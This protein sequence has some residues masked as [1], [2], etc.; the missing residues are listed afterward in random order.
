MKNTTDL[1]RYGENA[2]AQFLKSKKYKIKEQNYHA[3]HNEIDIIAEDKKYIVFVEVK[4]RTVVS[5][6]KFEYETPASAVTYT[7]QKRVLAA[8]QVYLNAHPTQKTPRLDVIEVYLSHN[9]EVLE[10]NHME[11]AFS[12]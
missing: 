3:S 5:N 9:G 11:D 4:T 6:S 12:N 7:K 2:A 1:G 8:A 10:I